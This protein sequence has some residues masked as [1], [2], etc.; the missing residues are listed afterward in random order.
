MEK[1]IV[2]SPDIVDLSRAGARVAQTL[3]IDARQRLA[4]SYSR[5]WQTLT[6]VPM[7]FRDAVSLAMAQI[8]RGS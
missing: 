6:D 4:E 8:R 3:E 1:K 7:E 2:I 5:P